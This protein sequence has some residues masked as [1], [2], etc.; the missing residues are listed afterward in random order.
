MDTSFNEIDWDLNKDLVLI[1]PRILDLEKKE[2]LK[3]LE[4]FV[5]DAPHFWIATSGSTGARKW[6]SLSKQAIFASAQ[7]VNQ[8]LSITSQDRWINPLPTF[9]VGGLGI[10]ARAYLTKSLCFSFCHKWNPYLFYRFVQENKGSITALV[11]TQVY[12]L[13]MSQLKAPSSLRVVIV[14]GGVLNKNIY[15]KALDLGWPL[16]LSY[17]MT[18]CASQIATSIVNNQLSLL[19]H[20][21]IDFTKEG[22]IMIK[23]PSLLTGYASQSQ[24]KWFFKDPKVEDWFITEDYGRWDT[25]G[26]VILGREKHVIKVGGENVNIFFLQEILESI[27]MEMGIFF[28]TILFSRRD[29]RLGSIIYL[30]TT[31]KKYENLVAAFNLKVMPYERIRGVKVLDTI[32]K[33]SIGKIDYM[34]LMQISI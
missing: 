29:E 11:P 1:N 17:G 32:P 34:Q 13:V 5:F 15:N 22:L 33:T 12:D 30:A 3:E 20:I 19:P 4:K 6:I 23:S 7:A 26:L 10:L 2:V 27:Q 21:K 8:H 18:E 31:D 14:G 9:H 16:H 24:G 25:Q 28:E